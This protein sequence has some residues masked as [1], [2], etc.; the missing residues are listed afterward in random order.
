MCPG[1]KFNIIYLS[2]NLS[3]ATINQTKNA[4]VP[5]S[6]PDICMPLMPP[7]DFPNAARASIRI[8]GEYVF[9]VS[10]LSCQYA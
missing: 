6:Q 4:I 5:A 8:Q 1:L 7:P 10:G 9:Y 2:I 3:Y